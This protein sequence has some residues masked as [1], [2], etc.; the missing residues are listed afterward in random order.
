MEAT[1]T[2]D[3]LGGRAPSVRAILS[4]FSLVLRAHG[5]LLL[6]LLLRNHSWIFIILLQQHLLLIRAGLRRGLLVQRWEGRRVILLLAAAAATAILDG[7][8]VSGPSSDSRP[9]AP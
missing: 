2:G 6:D 4:S 9:C 5:V 8:T 1:R 3:K 7:H